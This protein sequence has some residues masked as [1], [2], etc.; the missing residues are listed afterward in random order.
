LRSTSLRTT[1]APGASDAGCAFQGRRCLAAAR[2]AAD[3][4]QARRR[5][6]Q[7][8]QRHALVG[9]GARGVGAVD[10]G[11]R[12]ID[13]SADGSAPRQECRQQRQR[14]LM[15]SLRQLGDAPQP[16]VQQTVGERP[17]FALAEIHQ[18]E[19]QVV[20]HV[21]VG[22]ALGELDGIEWHRLARYKHD[23]AQMQIAVAAADG[24]GCNATHHQ[25]HMRLHRRRHLLGQ[26]PAGRRSRRSPCSSTGGCR[27]Q[28]NGDS[29]LAGRSRR[30]WGEPVMEPG[31]W[32]AE[33]A[34]NSA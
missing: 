23:V 3:R 15:R 32:G 6:L 14:R 1:T 28:W 10:R 4:Q 13:E 16:F 34:I 2:Q 25:L 27:P 24:A 33:S 11:R 18:G 8:S 5:G 29:P 31:D 7:K 9:A 22:D 30:E 19:R 21:D 17:E 26:R 20:E 12:G